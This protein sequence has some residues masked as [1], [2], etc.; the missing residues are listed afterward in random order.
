VKVSLTI[1]EIHTK[2]YGVRSG[3]QFGFLP[4]WAE[5]RYGE[6]RTSGTSG[7]IT[8]YAGLLLEV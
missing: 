6:S 2:K 5:I 7:I 4:E 8:R 3:G 1:S